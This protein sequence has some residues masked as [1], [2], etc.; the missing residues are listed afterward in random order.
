MPRMPMELVSLILGDTFPANSVKTYSSLFPLGGEGFYKLRLTFRHAIVIG[1]GAT[2]VV[3]SEYNA[4][5]SIFLKTNRNEVICQ[6][7]AQA[8][9]YFNYLFNAVEPIHDA[10]AAGDATYK[11]VVD[12]PFA[13]PFTS[14]QE[15][16]IL[17]SDRYD[18]L[19]LQINMGG[20]AD[21]FAAPGTAM[22]ATTL[23]IHLFR[24]KTCMYPGGK[25]IAIPYIKS[26]PPFDPT[27]RAYID[28]ESAK[29]LSLF[30]LF[31]VAQSG[32]T[33]VAGVPFT[34]VNIDC[35]DQITFRDNIN[36]FMNTVN[37]ACFQ[38]E[39]KQLAETDVT[40]I[41]PYI[42][43]REG[44]VMNA[45]VTGGKSE[46][47]FEIGSVIGAPATPQVDTVIFGVRSKRGE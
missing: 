16:L 32:A 38:E 10:M 23:D 8:L 25:P 1:T 3:L 35:L 18:S 37:V 27:A 22:L 17:D 13:S 33:V 20:L 24:S 15:D 7:P 6:V 30:G 4:I 9:Y 29:D 14:R 40:G 28:I 44:T 21:M 11:A 39:R 12:I 45:Y 2:P 19:D 42:F 43:A 41:Y 5:K 46:I 31:A 34:G 36:E 26:M 47:K